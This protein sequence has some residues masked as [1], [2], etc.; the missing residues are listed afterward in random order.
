MNI[1]NEI[2]FYSYIW[3]YM[4]WVLQFANRLSKLEKEKILR[5]CVCALIKHQ[6]TLR[7]IIKSK[8]NSHVYIQNRNVLQNHPK[9]SKI[10]KK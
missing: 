7:Y 6:K 4:G 10:P 9:S 8:T 3:V 2:E 1:M 5:L